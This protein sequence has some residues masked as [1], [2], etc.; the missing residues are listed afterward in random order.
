MKTH[1]ATA[2]YACILT[3]AIF[4]LGINSLAAKEKIDKTLVDKKF[5][6]SKGALLRIEHKFGEVNCKNWNEDAIS[7]KV[8]AS[9]ETSDMKKAES[10]FS[11]ITLNVQ[12]NSNEVSVESDFND[13][14]FED[15]KSNL[16]IKIEIFMPKSVKLQLDHKFGNAYVEVAEGVSEINSEYGNLEIGALTGENSSVE[17]GFG[18]G[19]IRNFL[20]GDI[21][22][23]YSNFD[24]SEATNLKVE[25][26]Y[27]DFEI[28]KVVSLK[29]ENEGGKTTIG[30]VDFLQITSK[31]S[32]CEVGQVSK[33]L[34]I[35]N[36]YGG[37]AV[38]NI[39]KSFTILTVENSFG[40]IDLYFEQGS[41]FNFK[42][43]TTFCTL[44]YPK[45]MA[46]FSSR[47]VSP[48]ESSFQG[49]MGKGASTGAN[50]EIES[51]YGG[52]SIKFK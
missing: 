42:A 45:D 51:E 39:L 30:Q 22:V 41:T 31:F 44:E 9:V 25:A 40:S 6:V 11:R 38:K 10:V 47:N 50:V 34:N 27:S 17:I 7:V 8:T 1:F 37:F 19:K 33:V 24:V 14:L 3:A 26:N 36:E 2:F 35:E 29:I 23:N 5:N 43:E 20:S 12:G 15:N 32:D 49:V 13:K 21:V 48:T 16:T 18:N 28:D 4:F 46:N 52:V